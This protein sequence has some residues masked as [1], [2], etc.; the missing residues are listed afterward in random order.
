MMWLVLGGACLFAA[1]AV[2]W[3]AVPRPAAAAGPAAGDPYAAE[4]AR[5]RAQVHDWDRRRG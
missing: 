5:F 1:W 4:V 3:L 2:I